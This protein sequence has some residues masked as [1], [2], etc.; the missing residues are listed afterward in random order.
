MAMDAA[1]VVAFGNA[2]GAALVVAWVSSNEDV[3]DTACKDSE[4]LDVGDDVDDIA[5]DAV[6]VWEAAVAHR[7]GKLDAAGDVEDDVEDVAEDV[8][9]GV[10]EDVV[11]DGGDV[12]ADVGVRIGNVVDV[13]ALDVVGVEAD[14]YAASNVVVV[15]AA[16]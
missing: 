15:V 16:E 10:V 12:A 13:V 11:A 14:D 1:A 3:L 6:V 2:F 5:L 8:V 4:A 9:G 7:D